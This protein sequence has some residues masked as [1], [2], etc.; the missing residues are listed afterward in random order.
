MAG[1]FSSTPGGAFA[2]AWRRFGSS[3]RYLML[4]SEPEEWLALD[5]RS[6]SFHLEPVGAVPDLS[7]PVDEFGYWLSLDVQRG[8]AWIRGSLGSFAG[9][10]MVWTEATQ[11]LTVGPV[12]A[13][14]PKLPIALTLVF[15]GKA[16][17]RAEATMPGGDTFQFT[18]RQ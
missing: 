16:L 7:A 11:T 18:A 14:A 13:T 3:D 5:D 4:P 12:P 10:E 2:A 6:G 9:D 17:L 15:D 1:L 8:G